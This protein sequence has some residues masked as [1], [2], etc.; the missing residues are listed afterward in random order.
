M[1]ESALGPI[2]ACAVP[3][4][5]ARCAKF[6]SVNRSVCT[7][8]AVSVPITAPADT[9]TKGLAAPGSYRLSE[10]AEEV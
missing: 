8:A 10:E 6:L 4:G 3:A 5:R 1:E 2:R 9:A 7:E